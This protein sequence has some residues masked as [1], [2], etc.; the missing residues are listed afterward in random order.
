[1]EYLRTPILRRGVGDEESKTLVQVPDGLGL[2][3]IVLDSSLRSAAFGM[4][5]ALAVLVK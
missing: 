4:T 1:M 3:P 2:K 5:I